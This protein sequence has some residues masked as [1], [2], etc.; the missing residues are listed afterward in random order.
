MTAPEVLKKYW[1]YDSFR[2]PQDEIIASV[3]EGNDTLALLPTGGGKSIC[4]QVPAMMKEGVCI[5]V[6]PLIALMKDQVLNLRKRKI[7]ASAVFSGMSTHEIDAV[8]DNCIYGQVK[9]LYVSPE[10]L[11]TDLFRERMAKMNVNLIA[12]DEAHC[13]S[14][15]G[16]DFRPPYLDIA[17][18]REMKPD[19]PILALTAS[20]TQK[21]SADIC[22][23]LKFKRGYK[24][25]RKSFAR[26]N[27][28]FLSYLE[29]DKEG[30]LL[31]ICKKVPGSGIIYVRNR[32][33]TKEIAEILQKEG[34]QADYYHAGLDMRKRNARQEAWTKG[35]TRVIVSTNAFGMGIDKADVRF[36]IHIGLPDSL[37]SYYQ[38]A[39]R[40]GRDGKRSYA[41]ILYDKRDESRLKRSVE[42]RYPPIEFVKKVYQN[43]CDYYRLAL[44]S[45]SGYS[46]DFDMVDFYKTFRLQPLHTFNALRILQN[47]GLIVLSDAVYL[48]PRVK[49][50]CERQK[51]YE[52]EVQN[53]QLAPV[54][55]AILRNYEGAFDYYVRINEKQLASGVNLRVEELRKKLEKLQSMRIIHYEPYKDKPQILFLLPRQNIQSE[56]GMNVGA[57]AF[58]RKITMEKAHGML[59]YVHNKVKCRQRVML[60]YFDEQAGENCGHCDICRER[61]RESLR[62][63]EYDAIFEAIRQSLQKSPKSIREL[64]GSIDARDQDVVKAL[65]WLSDQGLIKENEEMKLEWAG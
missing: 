34:I 56:L 17:E 55:Q 1:G 39:G 57:I 44:G 24:V 64:P 36:V 11:K 5:V 2:S 23:K 41:A 4:Y 14:Q 25:F 35:H 30:K 7:R 19:V 13:I 32:K 37:E 60:E 6:S 43:L 15:W 45:G 50:I 33:K 3:M 49:V 27:I 65:R 51:L 10:R 29:N 38:E 47:E 40:A 42:E 52:L 22:E 8:L 54:T 53:R 59:F 9:L 63:A 12:V 20:A 31:R 61:E 28:S 46:F 18:I 26:P 21:V 58:R 62:S 16:Y 48:S